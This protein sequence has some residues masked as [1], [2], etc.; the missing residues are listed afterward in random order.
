MNSERITSE[1]LHNIN[2]QISKFV[3]QL[4]YAAEEVAEDKVKQAIKIAEETLSEDDC[5]KSFE[6]WADKDGLYLGQEEGNYFH[7]DTVEAW[8]VWQLSWAVALG[9]PADWTSV[10]VSSRILEK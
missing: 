2:P 10:G 7:E 1:I 9:K 6:E 4:L 3:L 8:N 5:R